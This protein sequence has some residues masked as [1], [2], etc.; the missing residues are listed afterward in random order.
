M[1]VYMPSR[2]VRWE[3]IRIHARGENGE[4]MFVQPE[5]DALCLGFIPLFASEE[6]ARER[7][8]DESITISPVTVSSASVVEENSPQRDDEKHESSSEESQA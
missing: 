5:P 2:M 3:E 1:Q 4:L 6:H 7:F 8:A